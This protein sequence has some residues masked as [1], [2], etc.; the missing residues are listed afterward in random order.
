[1]AGFL[2]SVLSDHAELACSVRTLHGGPEMILRMSR[3]P[4]LPGSAAPSPRHGV[5]TLT[6]TIK[7]IYPGQH[8]QAV[9]IREIEFFDKK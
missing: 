9:A 4:C 6:V 8:G 5:T 2:L 7:D 3:A 1:M